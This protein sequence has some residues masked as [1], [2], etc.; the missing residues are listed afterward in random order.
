MRR[1]PSLIIA[2]T[3]GCAPA[4]GEYDNNDLELINAYTAKE[5]CSCLFVMEQ[6]EEYC[7]AWTK[8]SPPIARPR[9]DYRAKRVSSSAA[10][11]W[12]ASARWVDAQAGCVLED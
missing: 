7:R 11:I 3:L 1:V 4:A 5:L 8:A 9:I 6:T 2:A 12:G 10:I